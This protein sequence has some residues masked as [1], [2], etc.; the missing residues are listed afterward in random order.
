MQPS[1]RSQSL[2][3]ISAHL[4]A[5]IIRSQF[6]V[7]RAL[8]LSRAHAR[9]L[10]RSIAPSRLRAEDRVCRIEREEVG[11]GDL[12]GEGRRA[13]IAT[14]VAARGA[15]GGVLVPPE[16]LHHHQRERVADE[17]N[18]ARAG[19]DRRRAAERRERARW[20]AGDPVMPHPL[21][22][23]VGYR[24]TLLPR[25]R[26]H[27]RRVAAEVRLIL[28]VA[29]AQ[30]LGSAVDRVRIAARVVDWRGLLEPDPSTNAKFTAPCATQARGA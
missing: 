5:K 26:R 7:K 3:F 19:A 4:G 13:G 22:R 8:S 25:Q 29:A 24:R 20:V 23:R 27:V 11:A 21:P 2:F 12:N 17:E 9:S 10:A 14:T 30:L 15:A 6:L 18:A 28:A 16:R 1:R